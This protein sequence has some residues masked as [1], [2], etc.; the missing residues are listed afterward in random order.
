[1]IDWLFLA[2]RLVDI[3]VEFELEQR[4]TVD[5][6]LQVIVNRDEVEK[7]IRKPVSMKDGLTDLEQLL[8]SYEQ[9]VRE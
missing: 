4:P 8:I 6:L 2:F 7:L 3:S 1:M 5:D 9:D